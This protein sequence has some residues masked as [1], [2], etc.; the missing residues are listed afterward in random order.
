MKCPHCGHTLS[1]TARFCNKCGKSVHTEL[2]K[3][4]N[5]EHQI[6]CSNCGH[7]L[8]E[9]AR[10]CNKCGHAI[11]PEEPEDA[12]VQGKQAEITDAK[13]E[14]SQQEGRVKGKHKHRI[15][16]VIILI[17]IIALVLFSGWL[18]V[19][20][21]A[22]QP[23]AASSDVLSEQEQSES[24]QN[25]V[26]SD[27]EQPEFESETEQES[28]E[29]AESQTVN[30][31]PIATSAL[32]SEESSQPT[33]E[34]GHQEIRITSKGHGYAELVLLQEHQGTWEILFECEATIG[35]NGITDDPREGDGKT[36]AGTFPVIFC[37]GLEQPQTG[38]RFIELTPDS[39]WVDDSESE[40][41][42]CLT[43]RQVAGDASFE[44]T[45]SQFT[46][47]Y[48]SF[49]IFFANNGDGRTPGSATPGKGSI[50]VLEGYKKTLEPTNGDI[51]I[52][53]QDM[54]D[55]LGMLDI[56]YD[57]VVTVVG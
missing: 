49:N 3:P 44:E 14:Q 39:V 25:Q 29:L 56:Q 9:T 53:A 47:G 21:K 7:S 15:M 33:E 16:I 8:P 31:F 52:S 37:Y 5:S 32:E 35:R 41:Y 2:L 12:V 19:E 28:V 23:S 10:F 13:S 17:I 27:Q 24:E 36:P 38:I 46:N 55:L 57:P 43:T 6:K 4:E 42:N 1:D 45:Y 50:R 22:N 54:E 11:S 20:K 34:W 30:E 40:Y 18:F 26:V 51:K 48:F